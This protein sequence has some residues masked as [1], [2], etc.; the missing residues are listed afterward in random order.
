MPSVLGPKHELS[1]ARHASKHPEDLKF[2]EG[3]WQTYITFMNSATEDK[4][5]VW[6]ARAPAAIVT[7]QG[8]VFVAIFVALVVDLVMAKMLEIQRGKSA[9]K[10]WGHTALIGWND[11]SMEFVSQICIANRSMGGGVILVVADVDNEKMQ[12]ELEDALTE[13]DLMGTEV[14]F[15]QGNTMSALDLKRTSCHTARSIVIM[16]QGGIAAQGDVLALRTV[17]ALKSLPD[18]SGFIV[19]E[20]LEKEME[21]LIK[22]VGGDKVETLMTQQTLAQLSLS[23]VKQPGLALVY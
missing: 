11:R 23:V 6:E 8:I 21:Y 13:D 12:A 22:I 4:A 9:V 19:V 14:I 1:G 10:E 20:V 2:S 3:I 17:I 16:S 18:L 7:L 15:R 5:K